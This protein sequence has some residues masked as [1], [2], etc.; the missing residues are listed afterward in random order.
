MKIN[1]L[2]AHLSI[3]FFTVSLI[4]ACGEKP[5]VA[6]W[7]TISGEEY[8]IL[9]INVLYSSEYGKMLIIRF[10]SKNVGDPAIRAKE[11]QDI[12]LLVAQNLKLED[13]THVG[14]EAV[15]KRDPNFGCQQVIGYRD[16]KPINEVKKLISEA[17]KKIL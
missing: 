2:F 17:K 9:K 1:R 8:E 15:P 7:K 13:F 3:M 12:Y 5:P 4:I 10:K 11:L 6:I 16:N 14:L